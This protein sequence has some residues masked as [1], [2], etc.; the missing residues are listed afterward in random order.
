VPGVR[1]ITEPVNLLQ[2]GDVAA[3]L[4]ALR[5]LPD[6][7]ILLIVDTLARC[8]LGGDENSARD[9]G[10]A[11]GALDA[12][13]AALGCAMIVVHHTGKSAETERGSSA[14]RA[15]A[16]TMFSLKRDGE[17]L[18]VVIDKQKNAVDGGELRGRLVRI[19][20]PDGTSSCMVDA[21]SSSTPTT[22]GESARKALRALAELFDENGATFSEWLRNATVPET[23]VRRLLREVFIPAGYVT[24]PSPPK[25]RGGKYQITAAGKAALSA[26]TATVNGGDFTPQDQGFSPNRHSPPTH[27]H[28]GDRSSQP[29]L[30]PPYRGDGVAVGGGEKGGRA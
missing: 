19:E 6:P 2:S 30:S 10:I 28:G 13:R 7:P 22:L 9:M 27:R 25:S 4:S 5:G 21:D 18:T 23:T 12:I 14:L 11:I 26:N 20:L 15:A 29:P 3:L 1:F 16:D 24:P 8:M 17:L